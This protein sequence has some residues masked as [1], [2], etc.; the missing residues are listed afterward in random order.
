MFFIDSHCNIPNVLAKYNLHTTA[1]LDEFITKTTST[2][3]PEFAYAGCISVASDEESHQPTHALDASF[4]TVYGIHPLYCNTAA[5]TVLETVEQLV[6]T[7]KCV[8]LGE[9]GLDY[10]DFPGMNYADRDTQQRFFVDQLALAA[11]LHKPVVLHTREAD[12]DT[13]RIAKEHIDRDT[14]LDVH[15]FTSSVSLATWFC[16]EFPHAYIGIAGVVTFANGQNVADV[17][18]AVPLDRL[19]VET[20]AP[21]LTPVPHR[22]RPNQPGYVPY[23]IRRIAEIKQLPVDRVAQQ[24]FTNTLNMFSLDWVDGALVKRN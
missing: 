4:H 21:F 16:Q 23:I 14:F 10:H 13:M 18:R 3:T 1:E 22:R 20:D 19:L 7:P 15:C 2:N 9:T 6:S 5:P 17:V 11:R 12:E 24:L 8:A